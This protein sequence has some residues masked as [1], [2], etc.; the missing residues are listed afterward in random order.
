MATRRTRGA[1]GYA[2]R[3][4]GVTSMIVEVAPKRLEL[5]HEL[6]PAARVMALL[7]NP[8]D[9]ALAQ[10]QARE[11]LSAARRLGLELHVLNASSEREFDGVFSNLSHLSVA[12]LVIGAGSVFQL[13][14]EQLAALTVRH[15]VPAIY[16]YWG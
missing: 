13:N 12:G 4:T 8:E 1:A 16:E 5:L 11:V 2:A 14:I 10:A 15:K 6:L 3:L 7:V 9:R